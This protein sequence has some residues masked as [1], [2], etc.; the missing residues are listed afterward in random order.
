M[1][2]EAF[3]KRKD[4]RKATEASIAVRAADKAARERGRELDKT[5]LSETAGLEA[6]ARSVYTGIDLETVLLFIDMGKEFHRNLNY[7]KKSI[8]LMDRDTLWS[9]AEE[10]D[11]K[12]EDRKYLGFFV[13]AWL[14]SMVE[15]ARKVHLSP[16]PLKFWIEILVRAEK[17]F[18]E[19]TDNLEADWLQEIAEELES[20]KARK[21]T[22]GMIR[23]PVGRPRKNPEPPQ[24][25][26]ERYV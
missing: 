13:D 6:L 16:E 7:R 15:L 1:K 10:S 19:N 26:P 11:V 9:E 25:S 3:L 5:L 22:Y 21:D 8:Q 12:F 17:W 24:F 4:T 20:R 18:R 23:R 2:S 14:H